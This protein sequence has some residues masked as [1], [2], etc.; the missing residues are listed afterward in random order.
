LGDSLFSALLGAAS[1]RLLDQA[2]LRPLQPRARYRSGPPEAVVV[3][4]AGA[5]ASVDYYLR[6]RLA[7]HAGPP[8]A[9]VDLREDPAT[10][11][12]FQRERVWVVI[13][14]YANRRWVQALAQAH[15]RLAGVSYFVDDDLPAMMAHTSTPLE[16]RAKVA[17]LYGRFVEDLEQVTSEVWASTPALAARLGGPARVLPPV[18]F[19]APRPPE[20]DAPPLVVYH[21]TL[22]HVAERRF[23]RELAGRLERSPLNLRLETAGGL[24][25]R[26]AWAGLRKA[27]VRPQRPWLRYVQEERQ[28]SAALL[29]APLT[30]GAVNRARAAVKVF[31]AARLGAVGLYADAEPYRSAVTDGADGR[32]LPM[33]PQAWE[34]AIAELLSRPDLRFALAQAAFERVERARQA[35]PPLF[36]TDA[37]QP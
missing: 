2:A 8:W 26:L 29:L 34:A 7:A 15:D 6:P 21:G 3:L 17:A 30:E 20:S 32:L 16:A 24:A 37:P 35:I 33:D 13:C 19:D 18:P 36:Q 28:R 12:L 23:V 31:D 9:V 5:N 11:E 27:S 4:Q 25:T 1:P 10:V 14:R 22:T